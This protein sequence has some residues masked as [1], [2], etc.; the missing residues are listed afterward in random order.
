MT[1]HVVFIAWVIFGAVLTRRRPLLRCLHITSLAWGV[2][3]QV[4]PWPCPLTL[5]ENWFELLAGL[6]PYSDGF[7]LHYLDML[8]YPNVPPVLL[9]LATV[10][11]GIINLVVYVLRFRRRRVAGW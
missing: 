6:S 2:V 7:L 1:L 5:A 10:F 3:I 8:V 11:V 4:L 9:T